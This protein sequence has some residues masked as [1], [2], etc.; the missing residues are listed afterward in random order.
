MTQTYF[1]HF[2]LQKNSKINSYKCL[3]ANL[4]GSASS[5]LRSFE[6][7]KS[8][9]ASVMSANAG[10]SLNGN[11]LA[12]GH[13]PSPP[14]PYYQNPYHHSSGPNLPIRHQNGHYA[15]GNNSSSSSDL[16]SENGMKREK[17]SSHLTTYDEYAYKSSTHLNRRGLNLNY[18]N[19]KRNYDSSKKRYS[20]RDLALTL[21][22]SSSSSSRD[23]N[24]EQRGKNNRSRSRSRSRTRSRSR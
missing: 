6:K 2:P 4:K 7:T 5:M 18:S 21:K 16:I 14:N 24:R 20:D 15:N 3:Y 9:Q 23:Y 17:S 11:G 22:P 13:R 10:G 1:C 8:I 12:S 19:N